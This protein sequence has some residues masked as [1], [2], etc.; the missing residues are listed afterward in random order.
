MC[1][2]AVINFSIA[3]QRVTSAFSKLQ[4]EED[5]KR[6]LSDVFAECRE[7]MYSHGTR[8]LGQGA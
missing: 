3:R 5:S 4:M 2:I 1:D 6:E 8:D 7:I